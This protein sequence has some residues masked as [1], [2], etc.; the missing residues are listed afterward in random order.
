LIQCENCHGKSWEFSV[1]ARTEFGKWQPLRADGMAHTALG[2]SVRTEP[3][4]VLPP[5]TYYLRV[6][7][8]GEN[9]KT[10]VI[11]TIGTSVSIGERGAQPTTAFT[12][13]PSPPSFQ[14][15]GSAAVV[16]PESCRVTANAT[17]DGAYIKGNIEMPLGSECTDWRSH[18]MLS[19]IHPGYRNIDLEAIPLHAGIEMPFMIELDQQDLSRGIHTL[20]ATVYISQE[21]APRPFPTET[22]WIRAEPQQNYSSTTIP[23]RSNY[24]PNQNLSTRDGSSTISEYEVLRREDPTLQGTITRSGVEWEDDFSIDEDLYNDDTD[25]LQVTATDPNCTQIFD[26]QLVASPTQPDKP[27]YISWLNPRCC[28]EQGCEYSVW[29]GRSPQEVSLLVKGN[30]AGA[31]VSE[32]LAGADQSTQYFEVVVRTPNGSR[33]AAYVGGQGP[34]YGIEAVLEYRDRFQ[35][36]KSDPIIGTQETQTPKSGAGGGLEN[37]MGGGEPVSYNDFTAEAGLYEVPQLPLAKFRPCKYARK[38]TLAAEQPI[39]EGDEI[40]ISYDF[41]EPGHQYTLY[42]QPVGNNEWFVAPGTEELQSDA[43][44]DLEV[45]T[46]HSGKYL[47]LVYKPSKNWGCL[48]A[49]M[50]KTIEI[51]VIR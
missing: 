30:K 41:S 40:L 18:V 10:P 45:Q 49:P 38:T 23:E 33:K 34:I 25:A 51:N 32:L 11:N 28:Q 12:E 42:H 46:Y 24:P 3:L 50:D 37:R 19:Y 5:D 7:A 22:F 26:L 1:E 6:L 27:L 29:A 16:I 15:Q 20:Q 31:K 4:C 43:E 35:P 13:P 39:Y 17:L 14:G 44:F 48:S 9:C 47:M 36:Q 21:G 8:W 2:A